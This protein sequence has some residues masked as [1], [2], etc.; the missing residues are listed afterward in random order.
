MIKFG[1]RIDIDEYRVPAQA[2]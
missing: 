1:V 2:W